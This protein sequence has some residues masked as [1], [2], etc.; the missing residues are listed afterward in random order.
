VHTGGFAVALG[1]VYI[2]ILFAIASF[3]DRAAQRGA[4]RSRPNLYALAIS[5]YC[6][7]WTFF[8]S[9]GLAAST[10]LNFLPIYIGP[11]LMFTI[12]FPILKRVVRL[13]KDE[14]ITSV[15]DLLSARYG[16]SQPV[17]IVATLIAVIGA[18]PYIALQL[19]AVSSSFSA[20]VPGL[21]NQSVIGPIPWIGD[22]AFLVA[23]AL[24]LFAIL[25]G[26]RHTDA[27]EHQDGMMLAV[28]TD[29]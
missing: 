15:A 26:T 2:G 18:V 4:I 3:G 20:L 9:V 8:G 28:A 29:V 14:R 25:F 5:V 7:S 11:I 12:G 1:T 21:G 22:I 19:K 16:K 27:T 13:S 6:T 23:C 17:A 24:A 10:G